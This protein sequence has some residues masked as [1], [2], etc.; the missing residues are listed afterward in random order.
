LL[1]PLMPTVLEALKLSVTEA[2][3]VAGVLDFARVGCFAALGAIVGWRGKTA[4]L[5]LSVVILPLSFGLILF[6]GELW[7]VLCG[8]V[9]FGLS[10]GF[11]YS[12]ALYYALLLKNA[13][14]SAGGAHEGL[15]GLGFALGPLVG[16]L[17]Q[18]IAPLVDNPML[19]TMISVAPFGLLCT[20]FAFTALRPRRAEAA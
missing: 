19:A 1:A 8:E 5:V 3:T 18:A 20:L 13:S 10:S 2:T 15:I 16:L 4:P 11:T 6:G 9:L 14:V 17:G 7:W 12:A